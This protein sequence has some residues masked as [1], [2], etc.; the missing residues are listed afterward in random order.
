MNVKH[1]LLLGASLE[2]DNKGVN[3]LGVG[4]I[5]LLNNNYKNAKISLLCV[6]EQTTHE[7]E[8]TISGEIV[9]VKLCYFTKHEILKSLK[10]AY[11]Y[12]YFG[13]T[14]K[15][16]VSEL[17]QSSDIVFDINEGDSFSDLEE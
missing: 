17:I 13:V 14:S 15:L 2:S 5:T 1:I 7:K 6:G 11:L 8:L 3:A 16:E 10:E 12:K 4:A 9:K